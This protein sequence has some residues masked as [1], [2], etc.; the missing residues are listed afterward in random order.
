[1]PEGVRH[2]GKP[3][4]TRLALGDALIE[5]IQ[6][7]A[8]NPRH[9]RPEVGLAH[10]GILEGLFDL[11]T[12]RMPEMIEDDTHDASIDVWHDPDRCPTSEGDGGGPSSRQER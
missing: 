5:A 8:R 11:G 2:G 7:G 9:P 12:E 10:P 1:M 6:K 3:G 4:L